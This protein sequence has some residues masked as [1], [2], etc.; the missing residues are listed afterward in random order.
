MSP[1]AKRLR[2]LRKLAKVLASADYR[3]A[4]QRAGVAAAI[5]HEPLL[6]AHSYKTVVDV[7]ANR[8]QFALAARHCCPQAQ[9]IAFEPLSAP[10]Q[11][12]LAVHG[13]DP[14]VTLHPVAIGGANA[15]A[16]MHVTAEDDSSSLLSV[17]PLQQSLFSGTNEVGTETIRVEP[18]SAFVSATAMVAPALLKIDVQGYE[19]QVLQGCG[20][21]LPLFSHIYVECSFVEL[22]QGQA[23]A[24]EVIDYLGTQS[25]ELR[26]VYNVQYDS[27]G[28]PIQA[29]FLFAPASK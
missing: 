27:N 3:H 13:K 6:M 14:L 9:I 5:E 28:R 26:G 7:G 4:L 8:G 15:S 18:L 23:L 22:Y 10:Q 19:L 1:I 24:A 11:R 16:V 25:I 17:T 2:Q 21:L 20:D 29:D 12:F